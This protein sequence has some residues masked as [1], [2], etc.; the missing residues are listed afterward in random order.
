[1][2]VLVIAPDVSQYGGMTRFLERLMDIHVRQGIDTMLL[3]ST[4]QYHPALTALVEHYGVELIRS[5]NRSVSDTPPFLTPVFDLLFSWRTVLTRRPDLIVVTTGE[6]GRLS[7]ALFFPI[8][9]L[10]ILHCIPEHHFRLL[11]RWYLR[12]GFMLNNLVM[13]VSKAA[14]ES[15]SGT[16]GI[17]RNRI[18]VVY[19][20]AG[21]AARRKESNELIILTVGHLV[22][23][24]NPDLWLE[25][26]VTVLKNCPG[27]R[28][29]WL[30][31]GELFTT[32]RD[33]VKGMSLEERILLPGYVSDP[34][35]W[36]ARSHIYFQP[37]LRENHSIA[38]LE[39]MASGLPCVVA[40]TG[41]LPESVDHGKTG[42]VC[43]PNDSAAFVE[44]LMELL[45][46]SVLC[47]HMGTAGRQR[48]EG[49]FSEEVQEQK[50]NALY[51]RLISRPGKQ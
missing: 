33:T 12:A 36:Y 16:M 25:V 7:I 29:V 41:G 22:A 44:R 20:S 28:F 49:Y 19:N 27:C 26:A 46:D 50:I 30:G 23:Y 1:M 14:A 17:P 13:T 2:K 24:K 35:T 15:I 5:P 9:V 6:P 39:A 10:Y 43:S 31:D 45:G 48:V 18:E 3:V 21:I 37:S 8:P 32:F 4:I 51:E 38:V 11:P 40:N 34:S 42:Y 47:E